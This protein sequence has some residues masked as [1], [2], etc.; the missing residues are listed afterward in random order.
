MHFIDYRLEHTAKGYVVYLYVDPNLEEFSSELGE[1]PDKKERH[2]RRSVSQFV[3]KH[4]K[5]LPVV[6]A[7][8]LIGGTL[9]TAIPIQSDSVSAHDAS[10]NMSYI[11]TGTT[12]SRIAAVDRT[13][14][15]LNVVAPSYFNLNADGSL[16]LSQMLDQTFV[17]SMHDRGIKVVPF[18]S[19]HWDRALGRKALANREQL[20]DQIV[21][22]IDNYHLDGVN[23]DIENVTDED[24]DAYTD[25]VRLLSEKV[26]DDKEVSVAVAANPNQQK[27]GWHGSYDNQELAT[28][29]DYL[30]LMAYDESY[31][32]GPAGP[33]ASI[34]WV[35]RSIKTMV[36]IEGV[37]SEKIVLGLP[38]FG[39]YWKTSESTGGYG[40]SNHRVEALIDKYDGRVTFDEQ[41][42][43]PKATFT[44]KE[45]DPTT[46]ISGRTLTPGTYEVWY[47]NN[48]SIHAKID[49]VHKYN[50]KGT[51][52][53]S[54]GQESP[55][56]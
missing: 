44:I 13:K 18:L 30:L 22:A 14:G 23:V 48:R 11:F 38:F 26:P 55:S 53:W 40:I 32:G 39:R 21:E 8:V 52:S 3:Q 54:L 47:E 9:L 2:L 37:P 42:Q 45:S 5:G 7:K 56:I 4:F 12:T 49:L 43:S 36:E 16:R 19:N 31:E 25:L 27:Q 35:E 46:V 20:T 10:Y 51:G 33:V 1:I 17:Q 29:A 50:L 41:A 28:Y 24:R 15:A 34:D 6:T